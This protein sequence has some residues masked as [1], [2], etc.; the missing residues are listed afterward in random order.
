MRHFRGFRGQRVVMVGD[1]GVRVIRQVELVKPAEFESCLGNREVSVLRVR[2]VF[3]DIRRMACDLVCDH[4][5]LDII[6][7]RQAQML[8]RGYVAQHRG[9]VACD[10]HAADR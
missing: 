2:V 9:A 10:F 4:A 7:V 3:G 1:G 8:L 5:L 6:L